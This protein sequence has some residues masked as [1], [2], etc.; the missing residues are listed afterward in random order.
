MSPFL[1]DNKEFAMLNIYEFLDYREFLKAYYCYNKEVVP[2]FSHRTMSKS[3]GFTSPNYLKLIIDKKRHLGKDS[4][5]KVI[6]GL[7]LKKKE[8]KYFYYL[9]LFAKAKAREEK[10]YYYGIIAG[11][12]GNKTISPI[13]ENQ[14]KYYSEWYNIVLREIV[15][16]Q[17]IDL[18]YKEIAKK[19]VPPIL[20]KEVKKAVG[21]LEELNF[22]KK[23]KDG[24]FI[25]SST[26]LNTDDEV[27]SLFLKNFH[28][29]MI[30]L[31]R[32]SL[33]KFPSEKREISS[34]TVKVSEKGFKRLKERL[35]D[36]RK[37]ILQIAKED[38]DVDRVAQV[39]FQLFPVSIE[40]LD[41]K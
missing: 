36:F 7:K 33:E 29:K 35:Q 2:R 39:N 23:T 38:A 12:R 26:L 41:N 28:T 20:P 27:H 37:E 1:E 6:S 32:Q 4:L 25:Q 15:N 10:N 9:V 11:L 13:Y 24:R 31:A 14:F 21:L 5:E 8:A 40:E 18:D 17:P 22:I 19:V 30:D 3:M 34:C 16:N